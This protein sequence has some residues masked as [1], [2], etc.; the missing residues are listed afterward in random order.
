MT[1]RI[2]ETK[3]HTEG[4]IQTECALV[5]SEDTEYLARGKGGGSAI[6]LKLNTL[7]EEAEGEEMAPTFY[8]RDWFRQ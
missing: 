4:I 8:L 1:P 2:P 5:R 6:V 7:G 3:T